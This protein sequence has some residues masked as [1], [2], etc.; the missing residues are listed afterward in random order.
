MNKN[1]S[2]NR[3]SQARSYVLE[4]RYCGIVYRDHSRPDDPEP[5]VELGY[6]SQVCR[7]R[8]LS[9]IEYSNRLMIPLPH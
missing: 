4:C 8:Y 2:S 9:E 1:F 5:D 6:C 7:R 3:F